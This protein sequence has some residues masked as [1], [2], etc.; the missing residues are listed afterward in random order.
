V[1]RRRTLLAAAVLTVVGLGTLLAVWTLRAHDKDMIL[2]PAGDF[3]MGSDQIDSEGK[4]SEF[5]FAK[6]LYLDEH[7]R[8]T[9]SLPA[10]WVDRY[11]V[12]Q[13]AYAAFVTAT[14][15]TS[16]KH[17]VE[18]RPPTGKERVPVTGVNWHDAQ[19]YC[20]WRDKRLPTEAEWEKAA[21]GTDGREFPW[22]EEYDGKKANTG[23]AARGGLVEVGSFP[24][25]RSPY[26]VEDMAGNAWEWTSDWYLPHPH[27]TYQ[28]GQFGRTLKI[29]K[30][31][32]WG[33][34]G[35]Y[36]LPHFYRSA[37][38]FPMSPDAKFADFGFRCAKSGSS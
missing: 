10:Y 1:T 5:G 21:R 4:S 14:G 7:P 6:P 29:L 25:G 20:T 24:E 36:A 16:P 22:G 8:Q 28:S 19:R 34:T 11:E 18:G 37:Y 38:R 35:H 23:D 2:I 30:G 12:T 9:I 15:A 3:L 26:G 32:G 31:G 33:G 13:E 27:S 17:W